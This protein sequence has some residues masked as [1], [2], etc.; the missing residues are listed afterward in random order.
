MPAW[1]TRCAVSLACWVGPCVITVFYVK[2]TRLSLLSDSVAILQLLIK[3]DDQIIQGVH[4][5]VEPATI[6]CCSS[7]GTAGKCVSR[8]PVE[9]VE[10]HSPVCAWCTG[11]GETIR[12][13][14]VDCILRICWYV[15]LLLLRCLKILVGKWLTHCYS[16]WYLSIFSV[17]SRGSSVSIVSDYIP[18]DR[19]FDPRQGQMIFPVACVQ[20]GSDA[21]PASCT[22]DTWGPFLGAKRSRGVTL[23]IHPHLVPRSRMSRSYTSSPSK[24]HRGV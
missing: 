23:T 15:L 16:L 20:T 17:R 2:L 24:R 18:G 5:N 10:F 22:V 6:A 3:S 13:H 7:K 1:L 21:H 9:N 14:R 11:V 12:T 8:N 4:L 19:G